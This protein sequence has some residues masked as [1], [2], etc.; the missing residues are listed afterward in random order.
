MLLVET[1]PAART[2][3]V[4]GDRG[5]AGRLRRRRDAAPPSGSA[6]STGS[7]T[8]TSRRSRR[9]AASVCCSAPSGWPRCCSATCSSGGAEL[10]LLGA[11]GY[12]RAPLPAR[13]WWPRTRCCSPAG[14]WPAR[15]AALAIAPA[16]AERGGRAAAT[17][18]RTAA[19]VRRLRDGLVILG[20]S[21]RA[22]DARAAAG[23]AAI[24][25]SSMND[26]SGAICRLSI[27]VAVTS[28][29]ASARAEN[30]PQWRGPVAERHQR[31]DEPARQVDEDREHR[32]EA[33]DAGVSGST[34]IVWGDR[35]F[36]NVA[37]GSDLYLWASIAHGAVL[38]KRPLGGGN[39]R[40]CASRTCR[41]RRR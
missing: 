19:A 10:A 29:G 24:G 13:W 40:G 26:A 20:R 23:I 32:V 2:A 22:R 39:H 35:I 27:F 31:R 25:V 7:R 33:R 16:V 41:R 3:A 5:R 37:E 14:W 30:W 4:A 11:V 12:R 17:R 28:A 34:P 18:R 6:S 38:W 9:S 15:C 1:P 8:R 21:R 36:L